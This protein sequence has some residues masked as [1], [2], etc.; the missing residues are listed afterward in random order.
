VDRISASR[1]FHRSTD[2]TEKEFDLLQVILA[3]NIA[4]TSVTIDGISYV[5]DPG[6]C[7]QNSFDARNGVEHLHVVPI[8]K[9]SANQRAG[10]A[11]RTGP[12]KCFRLYT[13]WAYKH[14]LEAQPIP[15]VFHLLILSQICFHVVS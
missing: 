7:K 11:G 9:A 12:G 4:E 1:L 14:E 6:F 2:R 13:A 3:T 8:S 5:I 15:E 10:R